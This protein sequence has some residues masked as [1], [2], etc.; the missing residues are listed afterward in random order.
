MKNYVREKTKRYDDVGAAM[1]LRALPDVGIYCLNASRF[2]SSEEPI[3]VLATTV[4]PADDPRFR[5]L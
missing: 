4:Q 2:L 5:E 3:E 1:P